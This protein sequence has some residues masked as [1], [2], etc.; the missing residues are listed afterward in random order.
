[1][2]SI[3]TLCG[4]LKQ[5]I[6]MSLMCC[7]NINTGACAQIWKVYPSVARLADG[8]RGT[9]KGNVMLKAICQGCP[10]VTQSLAHLE[11]RFLEARKHINISP[12]RLSHT[13]SC[14]FLISP[15]P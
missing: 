10:P 14:Y 3:W 4:P 12:I 5:A 11:N 6:T 9:N 1:M 7:I 15:A 2:S 13:L 8:K